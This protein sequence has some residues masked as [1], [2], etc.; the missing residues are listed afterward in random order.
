M[1]WSLGVGDGCDCWH[2]SPKEGLHGGNALV[3]VEGPA[4]DHR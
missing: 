3:S 4:P 1:G 2:G